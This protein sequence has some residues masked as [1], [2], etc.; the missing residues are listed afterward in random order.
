MSKPAPRDFRPKLH[1]TAP[2]MWLNDPNGLALENGVYH[3]YYQHYPYDTVWGPM[4]WGHAVSSDLYHWEHRPIALYPNEL[5]MVF[6]GSAVVDEKNVSGL[7]QDGKAPLIAFCTSHGEKEQ[8]SMAWSLDGGNTFTWFSGN[9]IIGNPDI[10]DFRD[11]KVFANPVLGG[12]SMIVSAQ[13]RAML[14]HSDNLK[15]WKK[16]GEFGPVPELSQE[17]F[18]WECPDLFP[19]VCNGKEIWVMV[20]SVV[21]PAPKGGHHTVYFTGDFDGKTFH[22]HEDS[23]MELLDGGPDCYAGSTYWG[24]QDRIFIA[25]QA[26]PSYA[27]EVP[28][29]EYCGQM[30]L[31]R[32]F[33]LKETPRGVKLSAKPVG[34]EDQPA[35]GHTAGETL[36]SE[37]FALRVTG[38]GAGSVA[39]C[40]DEGEEVVF[41]IDEE[42]CLFVDRSRST[43]LHFSQNYEKPELQ[44]YRC[45]RF[46][47]GEWQL[48]AI[49]DVSSLELYVDEGTR[50]MSQLLFPSQPYKKIKFQGKICISLTDFL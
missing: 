36:S 9:P 41:G 25:W 32:I 43:N 20:L 2:S 26:C 17:G 35:Y 21:F 15:E 49:F 13:D 11:P 22:R 37:T 14:Y 16:T 46:E 47:T 7:G 38:S 40:N 18:V 4:H 12:F 8:Q 30:T 3:L 23:P 44:F 39:L 50:W 5:G 34:L 28:T 6:S 48:D 42:N 29:G 45:P 27:G 31:P 1:F 10:R 19:L 24:T 33:T